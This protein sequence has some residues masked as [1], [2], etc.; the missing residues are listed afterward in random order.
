VSVE[1]C[2]G[3]AGANSGPPGGGAVDRLTTTKHK[4]WQ[5]IV[6]SM[7]ERTMAISMDRRSIV[8]LGRLAGRIN[9]AITAARLS[10]FMPDPS[11]S[12]NTGSFFK[13]ASL[14]L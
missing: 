10:S 5:Q 14:L 8:V 9:S 13:K 12:R 2:A 6:E 4:V 1:V 7:K 3:S 11:L